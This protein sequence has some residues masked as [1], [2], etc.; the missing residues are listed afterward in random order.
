MSNETI[1]VYTDGACSGNPGPGGYGV[2]IKSTAG[3]KELFGREEQTTNQRMEML[4]TVVALENTPEGSEVIIHSD[5]AYLVRAWREGWLDK[6][7]RNGWLNAKGD[8][9]ANKDLWQ[10]LLSLAARRRVRWEK[11]A[12]H[13][14]NELNERCDYLARMAIKG[15]D[16]MTKT[17]YLL[18]LNK[19]EDTVM[20]VDIADRD[21]E[22]NPG[23]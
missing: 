8:P 4:A 1:V 22:D 6:W 13:A 18:V 16:T 12:G 7:Q 19:D 23:R 14:G 11:V 9:V 20:Y 10:R 21:C 15:G 17:G 3:I 5:S 2:I